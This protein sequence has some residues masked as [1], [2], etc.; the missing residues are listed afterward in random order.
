MLLHAKCKTAYNIHNTCE[1]TLLELVTNTQLDYKIHKP[2]L[3]PN[4]RDGLQGESGGLFTDFGMASGMQEEE[5]GVGPFWNWGVE[6]K[7]GEGVVE[8]D[9][10]NRQGTG[11]L[12]VVEE[13]APWT[14]DPDEVV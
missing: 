9:F 6:G 11:D 8:E 1:P 2:R 4:M 14:E 10:V 3:R 12:I 13:R 7:L 5:G